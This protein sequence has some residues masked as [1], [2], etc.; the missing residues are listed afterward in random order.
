MEVDILYLVGSVIGIGTP[1]ISGIVIL[2]YRM[3]RIEQSIK[4]IKENCM[5]HF[6]E[7]K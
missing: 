6:K 4:D 7:S 5:R 2:A 3:G 1:M